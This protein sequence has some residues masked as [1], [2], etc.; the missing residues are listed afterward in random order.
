MPKAKKLKDPT[1]SLETDAKLQSQM[2]RKRLIDAGLIST[3]WLG[4]IPHPN[5]K[6]LKITLG[7]VW[8]LH[9]R[10]HLPTVTESTRVNKIFRCSK[11]LPPLFDVR[12]CEMTPQ[13][14]T[15]LVR[16][17]LE[18]AKIKPSQRRWNF[19]KEL[20][21]LRSIVQWYT[22]TIDFQCANPVKQ[23][24]YKF[25][26]VRE[27]PR[28]ERQISIEQFQRFLSHL[29][30]FYQK[31]CT[32][33]FLGACRIGEIAGLQ[34]KNVNFETRT[35]RIQDVLT[36]ANGVARV[37]SCPKNSKTRYFY[38][39]DAMLAILEERLSKRD[40]C[41]F[42]FHKK[43]EPLLYSVINANFNRAW[44]KA[45]LNQFHGTHQARFAAAQQAR[46]LTGSID[47]VKS[48]T[49]QSIQMAQKYS[50]YT[51]IDQNKA[52]IE[53][54]ETALTTKAAS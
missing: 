9:Q 32:A 3:D 6:D 1:S 10:D 29:P 41:D 18:A 20:K 42:V 43:G 15:E 52:T 30:D 5:G 48:L 11:F 4:R 26:V 35:I 38:M 37:K 46:I 47:G 2:F 19:K 14:V 27:I 34:W 53:K 54:M 44:K 13:I 23:H 16:Q 49:G 8:T 28:R 45:G 25:A 31:I 50:D 17:N 24:H 33:Q 12:V 21:D 22:D 39:S 7:E 40:G 36:W 51:C